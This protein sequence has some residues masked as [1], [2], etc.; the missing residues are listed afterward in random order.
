MLPFRRPAGAAWFF[1]E[2]MLAY[3]V[4]KRTYLP[5]MRIVC[6]QVGYYA[7]ACW[8]FSLPVILYLV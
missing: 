4:F 2:G 3:V 6:I 8:C 7:V 1:C 5:L